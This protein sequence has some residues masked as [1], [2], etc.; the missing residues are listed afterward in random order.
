MTMNVLDAIRRKRAVRK[1]TEQPIS[2]DVMEQILYAGRRAQ[3]SKNSQPWQLVA[4]RDKETLAALATMGDF[5]AHLPHAALAIAILTPDPV[6]SYWVMFDAGQSAAYMQLAALE[7][8][9]GSCV[10]TL[11][12]PGPSRELLGYPDNL[13][14]TMLIA[15]GYPADLAALEAPPRTGGRKPLDETVSYERWGVHRED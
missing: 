10:T 6:A 11:H 15:F 3:S 2:D 4:I 14:L 5:T 13:Y 1:Y 12:R 7:L 8:G 9:V